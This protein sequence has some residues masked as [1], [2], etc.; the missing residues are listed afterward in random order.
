V[1]KRPDATGVRHFPLYV[2]YKKRKKDSLSISHMQGKMSDTRAEAR[3]LSLFTNSTPRPRRLYG[4]EDFPG[5]DIALNRA[6]PASGPLRPAAHSAYRNPATRWGEP[7]MPEQNTVPASP[8]TVYVA[9][10]AGAPLR[11]DM[12]GK[13]V[14]RN[15]GGGTN[16][17][18]GKSYRPFNIES[19]WDEFDTQSPSAR[20]FPRLAP[21][22]NWH[23]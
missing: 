9:T 2:Y 18:P 16:K 11:V 6:K 17:I 5:P 4:V 19:N 14:L 10:G 21:R 3:I 8:I 20:Q 7:N 12:A 22:H 13:M 23:R 15:G 1:R